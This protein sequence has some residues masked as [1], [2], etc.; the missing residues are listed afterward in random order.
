MADSNPTEAFLGALQ[1]DQSHESVQSQEIYQSQFPSV[2]VGVIR[3]ALVSLNDDAEPQSPRLHWEAEAF[4]GV[5]NYSVI[6]ELGRGGQGVVF[7]AEDTRLGRKVAL[8]VLTTWSQASKKVLVRFQREA[9]ITSKLDHPGI[10]AIYETGEARGAPYIVMRYVDG[11]TLSTRIANAASEGVSG[12][13]SFMDLEDIPEDESLDVDEGSKSASSSSKGSHATHA[14]IETVVT[15]IETL[16]RALHAAHEVGV[17]H[18]DIKPGN[19]MVTAAGDP[20]ILDFGLA[21][22]DDGDHQTLTQTGDLFGTPAYMAPEQL[23]AKRLII[24]RRVDVWALG[25]TLFECLGLQRPFKAPTRDGLY[26][27]ILYKDPI[28]IRK[29]NSAVP[30][31]LR[32]IVETALEKDRDRRYQTALEFADDLQRFRE[33]RPIHAKAAGPFT[34]GVRWA[35]RN[36]AVAVALLL[37]LVSL[38]SGFVVSLEQWNLAEDALSQEN[39]ALKGAEAEYNQAERALSDLIQTRGATEQALTASKLER[40]KTTQALKHAEAVK[41]FLNDH[42]LGQVSPEF[43]DKDVRIRDLLDRA[44][45]RIEGRFDGEPLIEA[46]IRSTLGRA[47]LELKG[48]D[49]AEVHLV[50]AFEMRQGKLKPTDPALTASIM[51]LVEFY[52]SCGRIEE[53]A[54]WKARIR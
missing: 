50:K 18:R 28:D 41:R 12:L 31:D 1:R 11:V 38:S 16:A 25:V 33:L 37:V 54:K 9:V 44:S 4:E 15:I 27:S 30:R 22:D 52:R 39:N 26:H 3:D 49:A 5:G 32:I 51:T 23:L 45:R 2:D 48:S 7:L 13:T 43:G 46:D 21:R 10:C 6:R 36:R 47:Y 14:A 35:Q 42:I 24:D 53:A 17:I 34:R 20:I 29:C 19:I 40:E 8:K